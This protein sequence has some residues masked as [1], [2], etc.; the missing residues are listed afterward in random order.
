MWKQATVF[1]NDWHHIISLKDDNTF[2]LLK[3]DRHVESCVEG[4]H[5][6]TILCIQSD[7]LRRSV[8]HSDCYSVMCSGPT[9]GR[10][11]RATNRFVVT[12]D[13]RTS[14]TSSFG[15]WT[16]METIA[17]HTFRVTPR[18]KSGRWRFLFQK[19]RLRFQNGTLLFMP[20]T[21][22]TAAHMMG[23]CLQRTN[24]TGCNWLSKHWPND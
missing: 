4:I 17:S 18:P 19:G 20:S 23:T 21:D 2:Q 5:Q 6:L 12:S 8:G 7:P 16:F 13:N 1:Q 3:R 9:P 10:K 14:G 22:W 15:L 11:S 24:M